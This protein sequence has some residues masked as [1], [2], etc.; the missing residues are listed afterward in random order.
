MTYNAALAWAVN[1]NAVAG[2]RFQGKIRTDRL[3]LSGHSMGGGA[4]VVAASR[5]NANVDAVGNL[6]S[7]CD[8]QPVVHDTGRIGA[9]TVA[10]G[11]RQL[12]QHGSRLEPT[13]VRCTTPRHEQA[14]AHRDG[15]RA[16]RRQNSTRQ[17][18]RTPTNCCS[19]A[20]SCSTYR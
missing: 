12:R 2:S 17:Q 10:V 5:N 16:H 20:G 3:G 8:E 15:Q 14:V 4:A 19:R 6:P 13:S 18:P 11:G 1:E 7:S 9:G